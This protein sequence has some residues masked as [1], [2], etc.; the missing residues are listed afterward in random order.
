M[1]RASL[2][3]A[4]GAPSQQA[5]RDAGREPTAMHGPVEARGVFHGGALVFET[6]DP[7]ARVETAR[8]IRELLRSPGTRAAMGD[9]EQVRMLPKPDSAEPITIAQLCRRLRRVYGPVEFPKALPVLDELIATI[10]SQNTTDANSQ[11]AYD[12]LVERFPTW[13]AV[14]RARAESIA[15]AIR[16]AG[17]QQQKAPRIKRILQALHQRHGQLSLEFLRQQ[18]PDEAL[19]FLR[20]FP[21]VGPKTAACVLLFACRHRV[22]P[23]D[24]HVHRL[25][26]RLALVRKGTTAE[27]AHDLLARQVPARH[28][29]DFHVLLI[30]HGRRVCHARRPRCPECP[31]VDVCPEGRRRFE[32]GE[33]A[34]S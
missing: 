25:S 15:A 5:A 20:S 19:V 32:S 6:R 30:R 29:L 21:G 22:L 17:L 33:F 12:R 13:D 34:D 28:V 2:S 31:L 9:T 3:L 11:A 23:V 27:K 24:T 7:V 16:P 4:R 10:L 8:A 26:I 14:R 18:P 1:M